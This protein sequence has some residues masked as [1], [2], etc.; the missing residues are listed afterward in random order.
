MSTDANLHHFGSLFLNW[1]DTRI[2]LAIYR[3]RSLRGAA[4]IVGLDQ[5]TVG[6]R[7]AA[8]ERALGATLFLRTSGGYAPTSAGEVALRAA[9]KMEQASI[10]L[11]RQTQGVDQRLAGDVRVTTTDSLGVEFLMTAIRN[12]HDAHP[13]VR[14]L[15][16]TS[17][18]V[19]NLARR[20]ADRAV[21]TV[22]P[23]HPDLLTRRLAAWPVGLFASP[24]Y[25]DRLGE[26]APGTGFAGHD[27]V[28]Y[29]P[30]LQA[31]RSLTL[32]GEPIHAGRIVSGLNS[33]LMVRAA[34]R[35]GLGI[36]EVPLPIAERDGL[37]R[38]WPTRTSATA[39][40]VWLVTHQDLRHTA[41]ISAMI[42]RIV[43]VFEATPAHG[44]ARMR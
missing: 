18:Q 28:F 20:E 10:D 27:L 25:L 16:N 32:V 4:R 38:I 8:L 1:D 22:K 36:G 35:A 19:Q 9:E 13:D 42:D 40:E 14:V 11:V 44:R 6:R 17:T 30:Y 26:P 3:E 29:L 41:R 23:D 43:Q 7:L 31:R 34:V 37:V 39:Y 15:L 12:L 2:F 33:S 21:R 24:D 5:A